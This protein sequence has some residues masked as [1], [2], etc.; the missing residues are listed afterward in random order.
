MADLKIDNISISG[1]SSCHLRRSTRARRMRI[2][3]RPDRS[4]LIVI[5]A[6]AQGRSMAGICAQQKA[7]DRAQSSAIPLCHQPELTAR[8]DWRFPHEIELLYK[9]RNTSYLVSTVH[10]TG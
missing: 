6:A 3:L 9:V 1:L 8:S 5:P 4:L 10:A 7:L 2:E